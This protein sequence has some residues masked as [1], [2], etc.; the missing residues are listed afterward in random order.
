MIMRI[1]PGHEPDLAAVIP[2]CLVRDEEH[3]CD[4]PEEHS[5]RTH[6]C[7]C[8]HGWPVAATNSGGVQ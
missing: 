1:T 3:L 8:G 4:K 5:S 2:S 7:S 6:R